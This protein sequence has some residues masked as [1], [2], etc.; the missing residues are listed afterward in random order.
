MQGLDEKQAYEGTAGRRGH[1]A[2]FSHDACVVEDASEMSET[3]T[4]STINWAMLDFH[5]LDR[6][7][8]SIGMYVSHSALED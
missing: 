7:K 5:L 6:R 2:T 8:S 1:M 4:N 3:A